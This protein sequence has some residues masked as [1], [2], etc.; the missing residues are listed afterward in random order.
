MCWAH[1]QPS[2][3]V[4][5]LVMLALT[6]PTV[7]SLALLKMEPIQGQAPKPVTWGKVQQGEKKGHE[8]S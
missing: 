2:V 4:I 5:W 1:C 6:G 8:L 7:A 3:H